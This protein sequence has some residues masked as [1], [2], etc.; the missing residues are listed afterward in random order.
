MKNL[1]TVQ[2]S[3]FDFWALGGGVLKNPQEPQVT[4]LVTAVRC[5]S[6]F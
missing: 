4:G 5:I 3:D 2:S 1:F 6:C